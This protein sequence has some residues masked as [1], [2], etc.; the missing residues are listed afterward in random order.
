MKKT[1]LLKIAIVLLSL[2]II[3][4]NFLTVISNAEYKW[5]DKINAFDTTSETAVTGTVT[6]ILGTVV[7]VVRI[8]GAGVA[9]IMVIVVAIKYM[10]AAPSEKA[11]FKKAAIP[12]LIGAMVLFGASGLLGI[13]IDFSEGIFGTS[14]K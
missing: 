13:I 4:S 1:K 8:I 12:Y 9:L 2:T 5:K 14:A 11:D 6:T 3:I 10:S 7:S